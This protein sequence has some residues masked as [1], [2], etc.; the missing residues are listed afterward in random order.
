MNQLDLKPNHK[1]VKDY[2]L[3]LDEFA[4]L[5]VTHETAVRSSFQRLLEHCCRNVGWNFIG[6][7][8]YARHDRN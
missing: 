4:K 3:G 6:E 5:D 8:K 1:A 7:Y 2:Y